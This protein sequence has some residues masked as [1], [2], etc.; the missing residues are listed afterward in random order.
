MISN[1]INIQPSKTK[2]SKNQPNEH[3]VSQINNNLT[4]VEKLVIA[5]NK[6][7]IKALHYWAFMWGKPPEIGEFPSQR[8]SNAESISMSWLLMEVQN[9]TRYFYFI[10][11]LLFPD[12]PVEICFHKHGVDSI[13]N[14]GHP[15][16]MDNTGQYFYFL[17][18]QLKNSH[19]GLM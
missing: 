17:G 12:D 3:E 1:K 14:A 19:S 7:N 16:G 10:P 11:L 18:I 13:Q 6:E 4:V 8:A 9:I 15:T 2:E 5:N